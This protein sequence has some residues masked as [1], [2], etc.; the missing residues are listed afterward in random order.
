[1]KR[2]KAEEIELENMIYEYV[3]EGEGVYHY[4]RSIFNKGDEE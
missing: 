1:M 4:N 3:K 2:T